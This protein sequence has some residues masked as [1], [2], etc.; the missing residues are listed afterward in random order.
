MARAIQTPEARLFGDDHWMRKKTFEAN[1]CSGS[2]GGLSEVRA[3]PAISVNSLETCVSVKVF[4][5]MVI[6][7]IN[8]KQIYPLPT[9][10][11]RPRW[12]APSLAGKEW[13]TSPGFSRI[14]ETCHNIG[15]AC[16]SLPWLTMATVMIIWFVASQKSRNNC[17]QF[18]WHQIKVHPCNRY[19]NVQ[20]PSISHGF[21][22][23]RIHTPTTPWRAKVAHPRWWESHLQPI[24]F[25]LRNRKTLCHHLQT[26]ENQHFL[27]QA[28]TTS[29]P[30]IGQLGHKRLQTA[31]NMEFWCCTLI[32]L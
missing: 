31:P 19:V 18:F 25:S 28:S 27:L 3:K 29:L 26:V 30:T 6:R 32:M 2:S 4:K 10:K 22:R 16:F 9:W 14:Q 8:D 15:L 5:K 7:V 13:S 23:P 24:D 11:T 21:Y 1:V 20:F 17:S 12:K